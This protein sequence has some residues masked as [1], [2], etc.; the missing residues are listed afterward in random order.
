MYPST[1]VKYCV[2]GSHFD[3]INAKNLHAYFFEQSLRLS[4]RTANVG[5]TV[6]VTALSSER[7]E[8]LF[9]ATWTYSRRFVLVA[10][11]WQ[12]HWHRHLDVKR[13]MLAGMSGVIS[14]MPVWGQRDM[15]IRHGAGEMGVEC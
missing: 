14:H 9:A 10:A 3:A 15:R 11:T 5:L 6:Q 12:P 8:I 7:S 4:K 2:L 13:R 1:K